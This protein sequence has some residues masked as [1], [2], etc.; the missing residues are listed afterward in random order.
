MV[1]MRKCISRHFTEK[2][3]SNAKICITNYLLQGLIK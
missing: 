1:I 3:E 2:P